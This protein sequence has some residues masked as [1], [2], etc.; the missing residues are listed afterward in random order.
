MLTDHQIIQIE[1]LCEKEG[2]FYYDIKLE[3]VDHISLSVEEQMKQQPSLSFDDA[4]Q[5]VACSMGVYQFKNI[6]KEKERQ[7]RKQVRNLEWK[8][9]LEYFTTYKISYPFL[10][11]LL[12]LLPYLFFNADAKTNIRY[13][14][15]L[16]F[17]SA[18]FSVIY[19]LRNFK[20]PKIKLLSLSPHNR[21]FWFAIL[22]NASNLIKYTYNEKMENATSAVIISAILTTVVAIW[23]HAS[24]RSYNKIYTRAKNNYPL[25]FQ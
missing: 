7:A 10:Y 3:L 25:A 8:F 12:A 14:M 9:F 2:V 16:L 18:I 11:L 21:F 6:I 1:K 19:I 17:A 24:F 20:K 4:L 15:I 5:H 13:N 22:L 23:A